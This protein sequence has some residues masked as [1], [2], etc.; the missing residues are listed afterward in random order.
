MGGFIDDD[1][2]DECDGNASA[3]CPCRYYVYCHLRG[4]KE[5]FKFSLRNR[6][7]KDGCMSLYDVQAVEH[8]H[9]G[10]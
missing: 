4:T 6:D 10:Q 9:Y 7:I 5:F 1:D 8:G 2:Y 3:D